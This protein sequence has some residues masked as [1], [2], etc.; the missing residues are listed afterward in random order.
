MFVYMAIR[1]IL[2]LLSGIRNPLEDIVGDYSQD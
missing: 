1:I 2:N